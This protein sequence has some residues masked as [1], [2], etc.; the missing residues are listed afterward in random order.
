LPAQIGPVPHFVNADAIYFIADAI[1]F[2][3]PK[4]NFIADKITP[5]GI[6]IHAFWNRKLLLSAKSVFLCDVPTGTK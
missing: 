1:N 5:S 6:K 2:I 3:V 4:I